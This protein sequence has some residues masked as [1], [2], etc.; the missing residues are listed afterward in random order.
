MKEDVNRKILESNVWTDEK[1]A[2]PKYEKEYEKQWKE[3]SAKMNDNLKNNYEE[4]LNFS[5]KM[6]KYW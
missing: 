1:F 4:Y 2:N 6:E 5:G 3:A